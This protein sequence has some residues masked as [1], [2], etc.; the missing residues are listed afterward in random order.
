MSS[1]KL[2]SA[3]SITQK[4]AWHL[5]H[6]IRSVYADELPF[7]EPLTGELEPVNWRLIRHGSVGKSAT[8]TLQR[9][10]AKGAGPWASKPVMGMKHRGSKCISA[11]C[12]NV[13]M[14][15]RS[16]AYSFI[17]N[18][19]TPRSTRTR[20]PVTVS[21]GSSATNMSQ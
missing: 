18:G 6:R 4:A 19:A 7:D 10:Y 16:V 20:T 3:M 14:V 8:N 2:A 9:S 17:T 1:T 15:S 12:V 21:C 5:A 13:K 11:Q